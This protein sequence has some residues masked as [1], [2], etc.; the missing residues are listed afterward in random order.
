[1]ISEGYDKREKFTISTESD[2]IKHIDYLITPFVKDGAIKVL[3]ENYS[4]HFADRATGVTTSKLYRLEEGIDA[5]EYDQNLDTYLVPTSFEPSLR[6]KLGLT[7]T[8][9]L[10]VFDPVSTVV[11]CLARRQGPIPSYNTSISDFFRWAY[12]AL[13]KRN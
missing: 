2:F 12:R 1:L 10:E 13:F 5:G 8:P 6:D 3:V 7:E 11:G 9:E 4:T